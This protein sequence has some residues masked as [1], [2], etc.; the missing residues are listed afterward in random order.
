MA[1]RSIDCSP[2]MTDYLETRSGR[3]S[4][5]HE[6]I[7]RRGKKG[8]EVEH[9]W[10]NHP[11]RHTDEFPHP[12]DFAEYRNRIGGLLLLRRPFNASYGDLPYADKRKYYIKHN[13]LAQSLHEDATSVTRVLGNSSTRPDCLS[14]VMLTSTAPTWTRGRNSTD[15]SPSGSGARSA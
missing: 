1:P 9:I 12:A 4:R 10:A 8:Y 11:D 5:Y 6:Y 13:L 3:P 7:Q 14:W 2:R 15:V